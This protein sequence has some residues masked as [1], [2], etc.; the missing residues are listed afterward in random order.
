ML[1][2]VL[3][4]LPI[5]TREEIKLFTEFMLSHPNPTDSNFKALAKLFKE[6]ADGKTIFPKLPSMVKHYYNRWEKINEIKASRDNIGSVAKDLREKLFKKFTCAEES[7]PSELIEAMAGRER[8]ATTA[9]A[10]PAPERQPDEAPVVHTHVPPL[11]APSQKNYVPAHTIVS[12][13]RCAWW[14]FCSK[15]INIC[16]GSKKH[17][18]RFRGDFESVSDEELEEAKRKANNEEQRLRARQRQ[19]QKVAA[20]Q[21]EQVS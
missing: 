11:V 9:A 2:L 3:P 19:E 1:C 18:C 10:V 21:G 13:R 15:R 16:D 17:R 12:E 6:K 20:R 14:P 4:L 8:D 7:H 5:A